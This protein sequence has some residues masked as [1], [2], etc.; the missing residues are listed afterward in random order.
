M[1]KNVDICT[2]LRDITL[3]MFTTGLNTNQKYHSNKILTSCRDQ[4][5]AV[6]ITGSE[7]STDRNIFSTPN[8]HVL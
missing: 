1:E 3:G 6:G 4:Y 5:I 2:N 8:N 7:T